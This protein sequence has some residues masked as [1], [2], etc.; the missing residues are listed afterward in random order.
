MLTN[1]KEKGRRDKAL[2]WDLRGWHQFCLPTLPQWMCKMRIITALL[3]LSVY[4]PMGHTLLYNLEL[5][6]LE[7]KEIKVELAFSKPARICSQDR[8]HR[9]QHSESAEDSR[10]PS[11]AWDC[12]ACDLLRCSD[13][14]WVQSAF[15]LQSHVSMQTAR[16]R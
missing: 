9:M 15:S 12:L 8:G 3:P 2:G 6:L 11:S 5:G 10:L 7:S 14:G 4:E 16:G 1:P 13:P